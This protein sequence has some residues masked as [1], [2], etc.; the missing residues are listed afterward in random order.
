LIGLLALIAT[1]Q[2]YYGGKKKFQ[3]EA[4]E[5]TYTH[6]NNYLIFKQSF[7]HF[8]EGKDLY[9]HYPEEHWDLYKYSPT[10]ALLFGSL[11]SLPDGLGL[12]IWNLINAL[13]LFT[14]IKMLPHLDLKSRNLILLISAVE[15]FTSLQSAQSNGLIAGL[16]ILAFALME[17]GKFLWACV[18]IAFTAYIKLFGLFAFAL[19]LLYPQ[20]WKMILYSFAVVII[21]GALPLFVVDVPQLISYYQSWWRLLQSDYVPNDLSLIG[22]VK[23]W[24]SLQLNP[25]LVLLV[26][27]ALFAL[28]LL[29]FNYFGNYPFRLAMLAMILLWMIVF[30]HKAESPTFIIAMAGAAIW[31]FSSGLSA[32]ARG[33]LILLA[34]VFTSLSATDVFPNFIQNNFFDPFSVKAIPCIVIYFT[35]LYE[36]VFKPDQLSHS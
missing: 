23:A 17:R 18:L 32:R 31:Y 16:I 6:Y 1:L 28:P 25:T 4:L 20:R 9:I 35:V 36:L 34:L 13:A 21:L 19:C 7:V 8:I 14:G 2:A 3:P 12:L 30:N 11:A 15:L 24:T 29:R 5:A 27:L 33:V 10:F 22:V 26:G